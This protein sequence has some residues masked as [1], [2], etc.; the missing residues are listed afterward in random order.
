M[1]PASALTASGWRWGAVRFRGGRRRPWYARGGV[2]PGQG[3]RGWVAVRW[4][5]RR[6]CGGVAVRGWRGVDCGA[7]EDK[8]GGEILVCRGSGLWSQPTRRR[9]GGG[10]SQFWSDTVGPLCRWQNAALALF[11]PGAVGPLCQS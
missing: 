8:A 9:A 6:R 7:Q 4:L 10:G 3:W 1:D 2:D 11:C 5:G